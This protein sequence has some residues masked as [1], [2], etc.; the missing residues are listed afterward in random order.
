MFPVTG[1]HV[2]YRLAVARSLR[3]VVF[4]AEEFRWCRGWALSVG[5]RGRWQLR[6]NTLAVAAGDEQAKSWR[7]SGDWLWPGRCGGVC[8]VN[9]RAAEA[10]LARA[11]FSVS[12]PTFSISVALNFVLRFRSWKPSEWSR[13]L[14]SLLGFESEFWWREG[15]DETG[16]AERGEGVMLLPL[17]RP[18]ALSP[19]LRA[20]PSPRLLM[21]RVGSLLPSSGRVFA[22]SRPRGVVF[23]ARAEREEVRQEPLPSPPV[24]DNKS[25]AVAT[26]ELFLGLASLLIRRTGR[27]SSVI[28]REEEVSPT[29]G[30]VEDIAAQEVVWEQ[31]LVDV[32][33]EKK[34]KLTS[35]G[36]SFSAAGLLFPYHLGVAQL[37]LEK[38]YIKVTTACLHCGPLY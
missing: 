6:A 31:R 16:R 8:R 23:C 13:G 19:L 30:P 11:A 29:D 37:L 26:G 12:C 14:D 3:R 7:W 36:F 15:V 18:T 10:L 21:P 24:S 20:P 25:F 27:V 34:R 22:P 28:T 9:G 32:E 33:A 17:G 5:R 35:P 38:G 1:R 2:A 4:Y